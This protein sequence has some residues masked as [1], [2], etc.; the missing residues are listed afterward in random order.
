MVG[1]LCVHQFFFI[2]PRR[3]MSVCDSVCVCVC[4]CDL[5]DF[6]S[7]WDCN[8][9][10][11]DGDNEYC[12]NISKWIWRNKTLEAIWNNSIGNSANNFV[13]HFMWTWIYFTCQIHYW[14]QLFVRSPCDIHVCLL[15]KLDDVNTITN[16]TLSQFHHL[17][18]V[19]K[20]H[21]LYTNIES[22]RSVWIWLT[23]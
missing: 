19:H 1:H 18:D 21:I 6:E 9:F 12:D 16:D 15:Y 3:Q 11:I 4:M 20:V 10:C 8:D 7:M 14:Y 13:L 22:N 17:K 23:M 2:W 5:W